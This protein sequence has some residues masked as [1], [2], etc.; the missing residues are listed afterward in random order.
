MHE[1]APEVSEILKESDFS[2]VN[3]GASLTTKKNP[4]EKLGNN[5]MVEPNNVGSFKDKLSDAFKNEKRIEI[6][7]DG[8]KLL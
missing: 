6:G 8:E 7:M 1:F 4:I 5:F 3:L 2:V